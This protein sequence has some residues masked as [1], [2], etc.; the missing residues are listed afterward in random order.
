MKRGN[1]AVGAQG[2][3]R[4]GKGGVLRDAS[5]G[6]RLQDE[7]INSKETLVSPVLWGGWAWAL[8]LPGVPPD[9]PFIPASTRPMKAPQAPCPQVSL[10]D[11][12]LWPQVSLLVPIRQGL[13]F[14]PTI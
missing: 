13:S 10:L 4:G 9:P 6:W 11:H 14:I 3:E 12:L 5:R 2:G 8:F 1:A 7:G